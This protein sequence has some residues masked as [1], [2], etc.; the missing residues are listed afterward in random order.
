M[1]IAFNPSTVAALTSPP[2]NKDI[3]FDL[4]GRNIYARGVKFFGTDTWRP[5][6]DN[7]TSSATDQSLSANMGRYLKS[8]IDGKADANHNHD[9]VYSKLNHNHDERYIKK[10]G[11]LPTS[12]YDVIITPTALSGSDYTDVGGG[13]HVKAHTGTQFQLWLHDTSNV[14]Y[15]KT[16]TGSWRKMDAGCADQ[17]MTARNIN[18]TS[19]NGTADITTSIWGTARNI[20]IGS[21]TKAVN[22]S[23]NVSWSLSEI[24]A[25]ATSHTH[26][27]LV[28]DQATETTFNQSYSNF[29]TLYA[30]GGNGINGRPSGIDAFGII[31]MRVAAG[32]SGQIL[33]AN[34]G[35]LYIR[36]AENAKITKD[37]AW[38][39]ILDSSNYAGILDSRYYTESEINDKLATKLDRV[40]LVTGN[41]NP[42]GY[43][44]AADYYYNGGDVS[45]AESGGQMHVSI[46]GKFW[47][48]EG[49]YRVLDTSDLSSIYYNVT[50][51]QYLSSSDTAWYPIVWGGDAHNNTNGST[52]RLYK[53][54]DKLSWQNS[55]QTLYT[56][57]LRTTSIDLENNR[58]IFQVTSKGTSPYKGIALPD[59]Q[60]NGIGIFSRTNGKE[61]EGGII[62]SEDT[63]VIYNSFDTGWGL[64]VRDKDLNQTD[65]SSDN[66]VAF[67]IRQNYNLYSRGGFEKNGSSND[68]VLLGAGG[69]SKI[70]DL[71]VGNADTVDGLHSASFV[72]IWYG[73]YG[74]NNKFLKFNA[75]NEKGFIDLEIWDSD[76]S[77]SGGFAKFRIAWGYH[78]STLTPNISCIYTNV[79]AYAT[80]LVAVRTEGT[81]NEFT[82]YFSFLDTAAYSTFKESH[83]KGVSSLDYTVTANVTIPTATATSSMGWM[84]IYASNSGNSATA[85]KLQTSRTI[86]GQSFDGTANIDNTLRI[87]QTTGNYCEG[88]RIQTSDNS[89]ATIILG[90]TADSGTNTNAWSIHRKSDN[91]FCISRNSSDGANGLVMTSTGMGL[92]N[93]SPAYRLDVSGSTRITSQ[94][95]L[96]INGNYQAILMGDDCWLGDC[97][98]G[99]VIGLS[100]TSNA[101]AGGIKFG[102]GGM[103]IGYN[104]S[105]HYASSTSAWSNFNA[106]LLDGKHASEF[107]SS[108]HNHDGRYLPLSG[109]TMTGVIYSNYKSGSWVNSLTNSAITLNDA[110]GSY[111]GWICGPTKDGRIAIS[112]YQASNNNLYFGYGERNRTTNSFAQE[113]YWDAPNNTLHATNFSGQ[114]CGYTNDL[115]T[116]DTTNTWVPVLSEKNIRHRVIPAAYNNA[117]S[118]LDVNSA[119][120]AYHLRINSANTWSNWYWSGQSGQPTWLWGSND[121]TNM[122]VWNPSNFSV[123]QA[124]R[125]YNSVAGTGAVELVRG[126]MAD[127]DQFRILVGGTASNAGYAEIAT[128]DDG[129]EPIYVRQYTGVFT[130]VKRTLT[131]LSAAGYSYFPSYINI[132]GN[133]G[134][135]SSPNRVWGSNGS[136]TFLRSYLTSALSVNYANSS[137]NAD[138]VDGYHAS[139]LL[140]TNYYWAN[141]KISASSN[142]QTQPSVNTIYA[143]NWFRST[144]SSGWYSE[145]YGGGWFMEDSDWIRAYN[146]KGVYTAGQIYSSNSIRMSNIYLQNTNEINCDSTLYLQYS[147]SNKL[148]LCY[149]GGNTIIGSTYLFS[150]TTNIYKLAVEGDVYSKGFRHASANSNDYMLLAGGGYKSLK[151]TSNDIIFLGY[152]TLSNGTSGTISSSFYCQGTSVSYTYTRGSSNGWI[153]VTI[154]SS[155]G[156]VVRA[157][158]AQVQY[159]YGARTPS[160][161]TGRSSGAWWTYCD[162]YSNTVIHIIGMRQAN[163]NNDSWWRG[164][165]LANNSGDPMV[166]TV[167]LFGYKS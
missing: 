82:L 36:S 30:G 157:A 37:L 158:T 27:Y 67:G 26:N 31:Q 85:T 104:G 14:W 163:N 24:G 56:T 143:N 58:G 8:L 142:T 3:T 118:T 92:G 134:N 138:T 144:G 128:A 61:D 23:I 11:D 145:T 126:D 32:W 16:G 89:W 107:A 5:V 50:L 137:G 91:N 160:S 63:C 122:Y 1:K 97:N 113:M 141:V 149:G 86:W 125:T 12:A 66:T 9:S 130:T 62:I 60:G 102:K 127:N 106:D 52:G 135:N 155:A 15:K 93:T 124:K 21:T 153:N 25:A 41:W 59:L 6:V 80:R 121:G 116:A 53:S 29:R 105:N 44:L 47:Q 73:E 55:S 150:I 111:G 166:I 57:K 22:G 83:S 161:G 70:T 148:S 65:I 110:S 152:L 76:N 119:T 99:N 78:T 71:S 98:I 109:G 74:Y 167:L 151:G 39:Q 45:F 79:T 38:R 51:N 7:L 13:L 154:N 34:G 10:V 35:S 146:S 96:P 164:N 112:T 165:P 87:R 139:S 114:W 108:S 17:L 28:T 115:A 18:G 19:F 2:N 129:T 101:N 95:F 81:N 162:V 72:R 54:Y 20:T 40:N 147:N 133:E 88:I 68:Y 84:Q 131:L 156:I 103:Y 132:G 136:D 43:N 75:G 69:H 33:Y 48:N 117:P 42:R 123:A 77:V 46:D 4:T 94:L 64:S 49:K 100:G 90:A 140:P 159:V 120:Y